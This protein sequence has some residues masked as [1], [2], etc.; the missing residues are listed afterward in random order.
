MRPI[1]TT[2]I[3]RSALA[4]L[5]FALAT[6]TAMAQAP[7]ATVE[8]GNVVERDSSSVMR[9]PGTVMSTR[10]ALISAELEGRL[11][12]VA[13]VG[14]RVQ[15]GQPVATI[16]DHLLQLQLRDNEAGIRRIQA[17]LAYNE[18]QQQRLEKLAK[19]NNMAQSELDEVRSRL[20]ML[21]QDLNMAEVERDRTRYDLQRSK[22]TAPF[23][24][25]VVS[26]A[27]TAGEF[28]TVGEGLVRL[29]DVDALEVS[30]SAP[31]RVARY[32]Q[33]GDLL[34]LQS[35]E[36]HSE[37]AIRGVVPVGDQRSRMMEFRLQLEPGEWL[38]GEAVT[39][40][41]ADSPATA[42]LSVPR[43][44]LVL[45]NGEVYVFGVNEDG[46][47]RRIPVE[48]RAGHGSQIAIDGD[49]QAGD[50]VVIRGAE[51]LQDGQSV[52][53]IRQQLAAS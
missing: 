8:L 20:Q 5:A 11:V 30:V 48:T 1:C 38:I 47:A 33:V 16:D 52:K 36:R 32:N 31:L 4:G 3:L 14:E 41:L 35:G 22:V 39:V 49:L 2:A 6:H 27:M 24:G 37:A 40:E 53:V 44:A 26:R 19:Q 28:T 10:D 17:D 45:R 25:I 7:A 13:E 21:Q 51:R 12:W 15:Q 34:Q 50:A 46:T 29:V 43:D 9:L 23:D 18:R 42:A